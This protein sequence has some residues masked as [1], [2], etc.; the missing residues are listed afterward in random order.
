MCSS[1]VLGRGRMLH[2]S[3]LLDHVILSLQVHIFPL[4]SQ[5]YIFPSCH[6]VSIRQFE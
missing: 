3:A 6:L 4:T 2:S 5:L 1:Y